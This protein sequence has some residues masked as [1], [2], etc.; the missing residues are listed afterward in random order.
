MRAPRL[1]PKLALSLVSIVLFYGVIEAATRLFWRTEN[2]G[3]HCAMA[4][5]VLINV[6]KPS[7]E[8][9][10]KKTE[11]AL[12][13]FRF[14]QFA[15]RD[16]QLIAEPEEATLE[17]FAVGDSFTMGAMVPFES[18]YVHVAETDLSARLGHPVAFINGGVSSWDLPQYLVRVTEAV[19]RGAD[20]ITVGVLANDLFADI[21]QKGLDERAA[22]L[23]GTSME[24]TYREI[25]MAKRPLPERLYRAVLSNSRA[26]DLFMH[27][28]MSSD[29]VYAAA[30]L[31]REGEDSYLRR[32]LSAKWVAKLGDAERLLRRM[33]ET[34]RDGGAKLVV[35][36]IPQRIQALLL[37]ESDRYPDLDAHALSSQLG[38]I[39]R[40]LDIP[41]IDYLDSLATL[42]R[43][44]SL[45]FPVDGHLT[46]E[47]QERL[48]H[49]VADRLLELGALPDA[50]AQ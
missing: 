33:S 26:L 46:S 29:A 16:E 15:Y 13:E 37:S 23:E 30:Y 50:A 27:V 44:T 7:C 21:S 20:V 19:N 38:R 41:Y 3:G 49:F 25:Y 28:A 2:R 4:D 10:D 31:W 8:F 9:A 11:G 43:P 17:L 47:G 42:E 1:L 12:V 24:E 5:R 18:T 14:N 22:L 45:Y 34:A 36:S 40:S 6:H 48:G 39:C 32:T 35:I